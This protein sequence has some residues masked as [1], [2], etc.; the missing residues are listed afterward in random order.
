MKLKRSEI[1]SEADRIVGERGTEAGNRALWVAWLEHVN[2]LAVDQRC[3]TCAGPLTLTESSA[4]ES[5]TVN[6]PCGESR[7]VFRGL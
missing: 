5:W 2:G 1:E 6:C 3:P 4:G 7:A